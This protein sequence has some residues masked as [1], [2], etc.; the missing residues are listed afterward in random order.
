MFTGGFCGGWGVGSW[1]VMISFWL[2]VVGVVVWVV[3]RLFPRSDDRDVAE[4]RDDPDYELAVGDLDPDTYRRLRGDLV[5]AGPS[6]SSQ[7]E[8]S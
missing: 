8:S 1:L 3:S 5:D 4:V 6:Q 7:R 2:L